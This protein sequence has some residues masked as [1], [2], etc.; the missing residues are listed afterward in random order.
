M[1]L[2]KLI[3]L[4]NFVDVNKG[5]FIK[6]QRVEIEEDVANRWIEG[7]L[8]VEDTNEPIKTK[9]SKKKVQ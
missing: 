9:S 7:N 1:N 8:V 4:K 3:V 2:K 5:S 6:N